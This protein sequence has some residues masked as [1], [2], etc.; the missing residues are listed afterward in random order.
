[1]A[2]SRK[3]RE[4]NRPA[5]IE[6]CSAVLNFAFT[7]LFPYPPPDTSLLRY[8]DCIRAAV[9]NEQSPVVTRGVGKMESMLPPISPRFFAPDAH[10]LPAIGARRAKVAMLNGCVM[11]LLF[12]DV[13]EATVRVL[14]RN[15]CDVIFPENKSVAARST[16]TTAKA[17]RRENNGPPLH[18]CFPR[19]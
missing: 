14:R 16:F 3:R 11:P 9:C 19:R 8:C 4:N 13:N 2:A 5:G 10:I 1:M 18:R 15:G 6:A 12:S 17:Q 7:Q